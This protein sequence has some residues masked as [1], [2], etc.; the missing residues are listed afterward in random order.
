M[1]DVSSALA[2]SSVLVDRDADEIG[3]LYALAKVSIVES[4]KYQIACGERLAAKKA[5]MGHGEWL[6]WL[7]ENEGV[8]GFGERSA[9]MLIKVSNT[10]PASDL[11]PA[12]ALAISRQLWG[13]Q[14]LE[15]LRHAESPALPEGE[16][17][18]IYADP[19]WRYEFSESASR[20]IENHYPTMTPEE[21]SALAVPA[22][23]DCILF[24]WA[25]SPK[26]A[27]AMTVIEAWDFVYRTCMV[28]VKDK[29]GMGYY[30]RQRHELL[31]IAAKGS[32]GAPEP[33]DRPDSVIESPRTGHSRKPDMWPLLKSMYPNFRYLEMFSR[34]EAE[35]VVSWGWQASA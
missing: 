35:G 32:P 11:E 23:K 8:L 31:L 26:L 3:R 4:V 16:Y 6:P 29:I 20:E 18:L 17:N 1:T 15:K 25:T 34:Q 12:E 5:S 24:L 30:S 13:H 2:L 28:W 22:A 10:K 19:P 7:K 9:Q 33:K 14:R 21:I 27:E